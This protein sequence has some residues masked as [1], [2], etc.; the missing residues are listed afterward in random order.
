M[1]SRRSP[2]LQVTP[3]AAGLRSNAASRLPRVGGESLDRDALAGEQQRA[4]EVVLDQR[5]G[6]EALGLARRAPRARAVPRWSRNSAPATQREREQDGGAAEQGAQAPVRAPRAARLAV[7]L[8][9]A[10]LQERALELR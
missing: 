4:V 10:L 6:A 2:S 8:G 7:G 3:T 9:P 1:R 5:L